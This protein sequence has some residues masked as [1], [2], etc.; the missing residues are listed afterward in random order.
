MFAF[1]S[2]QEMKFLLFAFELD[3]FAVQESGVCNKPFAAKER[4]D[5]SNDNQQQIFAQCNYSAI[6]LHLN[7]RLKYTAKRPI[8]I[9][10]KVSIFLAYV[11]Y[12]L[13]LYTYERASYGHIKSTARHDS[14]DKV[15]A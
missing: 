14:R 7:P 9:Q 4:H 13:Y 1:H 12:F 10:N 11:R 2:E 15:D 6:A 8:K 3:V 5:K